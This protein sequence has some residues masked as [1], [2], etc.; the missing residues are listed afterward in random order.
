[1]ANGRPL[2][3]AVADHEVELARAGAH[4]EGRLGA[5]LFAARSHPRSALATERCRAEAPPWRALRP[6]HWSAC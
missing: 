5:A 6:G 3:Q 4:V 2:V 1:M